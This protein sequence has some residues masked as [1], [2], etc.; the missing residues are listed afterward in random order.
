MKVIQHMRENPDNFKPFITVGEGQRRNPKRK[1]A[2]AL[3]SQF[4]FQ[5]PTEEQTE[6]AWE[7]HLERMAQGGTYGDNMEIRA[8]TQAY[9]TDV[10]I[11]QSDLA[12][13]VRVKDDGVVRPVAFIAY[14]VRALYDFV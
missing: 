2:G 11:F 10:K 1:N 5:P 13:Y 9:N 8:F 14:H 6:R 3:S 4:S 7:Q 12:Y